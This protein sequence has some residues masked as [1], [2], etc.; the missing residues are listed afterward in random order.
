MGIPPTGK[1]VTLTG[2]SIARI[3]DGK[4]AEVWGASDQVGLMQQLGA[5]PA[6]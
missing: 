1:K 6:Q 2:I 4:I 5:T 3:A